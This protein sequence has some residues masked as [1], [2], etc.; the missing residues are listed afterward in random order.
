M[1]LDRL[2]AM[3]SYREGGDDVEN[4]PPATTGS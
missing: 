4:A 1:A 2:T 3:I